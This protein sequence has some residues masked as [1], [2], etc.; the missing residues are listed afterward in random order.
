[1]I[2]GAVEEVLRADSP[3][4]FTVRTPL[5]D[6]EV[7]GVEIGAGEPIFVYL[8]AANRD[9]AVWPDP[10]TLDIGRERG[11]QLAFG[12]GVHLCIGAPLARLEAQAGLAAL[13]ERFETVRFGE[14]TRPRTAAALL[15]GF[16]RLPLI[17]T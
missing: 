17:F 15:R 8:A 3:V 16:Q 6:V 7:G 5:T 13:L 4:Q 11:R 12:F 14:G 1:M 10:E 2:E 9:A